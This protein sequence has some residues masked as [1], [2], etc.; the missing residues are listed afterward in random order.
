LSGIPASWPGNWPEQANS[1]GELLPLVT[2][3][4]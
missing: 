3:Q 4:R 1:T 2:R